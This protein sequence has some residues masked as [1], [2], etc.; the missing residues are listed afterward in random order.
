MVANIYI[1]SVCF[2]RNGFKFIFPKDQYY[3]ID[4]KKHK[5]MIFLIYSAGLRISELINMRKEDI[6][7][8]RKM[9]FVKGGKGKMDRYTILAESALE[10]MNDYIKEYK[11]EKYLFEGQYGG[12]YSSTSLR[13]I[14]HRAKTKAGVT[15]PGSVHTLRHSFATHL[16]ENGTDLRYIQELLGHS[17]SKTTEIYT[18][19]STLNISQITSPGD[20]I[21]L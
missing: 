2:I 18:H 7:V 1:K 13:K 6:L 20:M 9:V 16:F 5:T 8:D 11:P 4:N 19:V 12:K 14:L 3:E 15:T 17:S 10:L 21:N